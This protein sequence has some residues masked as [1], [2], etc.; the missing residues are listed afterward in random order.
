MLDQYSDLD[1]VLSKHTKFDGSLG[2]YH[3]QKAR[4]YL[5]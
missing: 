2:V 3:H 5:Y 1:A 4:F